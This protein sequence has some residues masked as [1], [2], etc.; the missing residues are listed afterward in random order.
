MSLKSSSHSA[1]WFLS[2]QTGQ[3]VGKDRSGT[4]AGLLQI[5]TFSLFLANA[6]QYPAVETASKMGNEGMEFPL[7]L[8]IQ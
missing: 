7:T 5:Q 1:I 2:Q 6:A 8:F 3:E 4:R